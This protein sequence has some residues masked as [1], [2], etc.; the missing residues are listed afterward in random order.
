TD[1]T[2]GIE[3]LLAAAPEAARA[4]AAQLDALNSERRVLQERM[5]AEAEEQLAGLAALTGAGSATTCLFDERWHPGIVGLIASRIREQTGQPAI[6]FARAAEP[7]LLRGSARSVEGV[8]VRDVIAN[9]LAGLPV[10]DI[11]FGGHAMAAGLTL[12]EA[13]FD[14]FQRAFAAEL[15]RVSA[16]ATG[17]DTLWTDGGLGPGDLGLDLAEALARAGPWG[18][19]F[20]EPLFDN[21]FTVRGQR[22]VGER[23]LK[24]RVQHVEGG[25]VLDA[26]AFGMA[27]LADPGGQARLVY[28]LD[29]NHFRDATTAQLVVEH[30]ECV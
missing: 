24:L 27:P 8:H 11:R 10:R 21:V 13:E 26:I 28:R 22:V 3:C 15:D 20:P 16:G 17:A 23:H 30:L 2:I 4:H 29:V 6:A 18:Q 25:P 19:A 7:G 5:Q 14:V 1:M 9:A 12:P